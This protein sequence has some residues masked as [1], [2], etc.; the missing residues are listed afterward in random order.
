MCLIT[1]T[2]CKTQIS[3][4]AT[5]CPKCGA[6]RPVST[7]KVIAIA[8]GVVFVLI[9]AAA[10]LTPESREQKAFNKSLENSERAVDRLNE[11]MRK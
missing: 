4:T 2:E 6:K 9:V 8:V 1:C 7:M 5:S 11:L 10:L 3:D